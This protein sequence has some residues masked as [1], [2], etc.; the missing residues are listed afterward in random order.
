MKDD[1]L[2]EVEAYI[3][4]MKIGIL[5]MYQNRVYFEYDDEFRS[6]N[7]NISPLKLNIKEHHN[8]YTN[9]DKFDIYQGISGVF[10]DTLPDK[11]G[12]AF[13]Y[14]YFENKGFSSI[15]SL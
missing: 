15:V 12:M 9:K 13:I 5:T 14:R 7:I 3:Y 1:Y 2:L 8:G 6:K 11:H 10:F 4:N